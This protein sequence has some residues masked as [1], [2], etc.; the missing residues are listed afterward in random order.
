MNIIVDESIGFVSD[1][2]VDVVRTELR[3]IYDDGEI[4]LVNVFFGGVMVECLDGN[5]D[6][7]DMVVDVAGNLKLRVH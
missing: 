2:T 7:Y 4:G 6:S 5:T 1:E 3:E